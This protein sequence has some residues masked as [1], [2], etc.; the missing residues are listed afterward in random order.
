M[1]KPLLLAAAALPLIAAAPPPAGPLAASFRS[2]VAFLADDL[3]E[4]RGLG[5]RGHEI[6]ANYIAQHF[7]R[8]G[9]QPA[10]TNSYVQRIGFAES[11]FASERESALLDLG[12][13]KLTLENGVGLVVSPGSTAG[14]EEVT[15]E[16]V[17]VGYGLQDPSQGIDDYAGLDLKGKY[18]V[19]LSGAPDGMNSEIAAHLARVSKATGAEAAGA[20][21]VITIRTLKEAERLPWDKYAGRARLPRRLVLDPNGQPLGDG[22]GLKV[23][24]AIDDAAATALF[25]GAPM[26][27][28]AVRAAAQKGMV[29]GFPLPGRFTV[30]RATSVERIS[31]PNVLALL[32]G[33]D[34]TLGREIVVISA[35][36]DHVGMKVGAKPG[37]DA[38]Y[39]GAM[40]NAA[41]TATLLEAAT[42][43]V[44]APPKRTVLFLATTAEE[45]GLL[46]ADYF[47]RFPT[48]DV[49]R[50]V[51]DVNIDMPILTCDFGDIVAFGGERS[52]IG[53][54]VAQAAKAEKLGVSPDPQPE[55]AV[56]TRSDHYPF[57][58][59]GVPSVFLKTGWTDTKGGLAC[60][61]AERKF[62]L[63]NYHEVSDQ[64]DLPFDWNA[65][66]KWTRLNI[67]IIRGLANAKAAPRWY[68][69]DYFGNA[70][71][72]GA[73][74]AKK[75]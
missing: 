8:L 4:G 64:L 36:S 39:N 51:A 14:A 41:G 15:G 29:K 69:G 11:R 28:A 22:A 30:R 44:K 12:A 70:F 1:N 10:G 26:D 75:P 71:A 65:A 47:S 67:G 34:K 73:P 25:A 19:V 13:T 62:R 23:R 5:S 17:F 40:D 50:I 58:R 68:E 46:G 27:F 43:L 45:S 74:K 55:E 20:I 54:L 57:V 61:E 2:H 37:E 38:I 35:H 60:K 49:K 53:T 63:N 33:T 56:F 72:A 16:M 31:S 59:K 3:L 32:P 48:V 21:G 42:A 6:A 7:A 66:A 52:T 24:A 18:A 9:L